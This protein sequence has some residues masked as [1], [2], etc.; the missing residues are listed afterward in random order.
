MNTIQHGNWKFDLVP[1]TNNRFTYNLLPSSNT[2]DEMHFKYDGTLYDNN[3]EL[4]CFR[5]ASIIHKLVRNHAKQLLVNGAKYIDIVES[6]ENTIALY[7]K[8]NSECKTLNIAFPIGLNVNAIAAHDSAMIDDLRILHVGDVVKCDIGIQIDGCIVDSAF[9]HIVGET[10]ES[11][12]SHELYPLIEAT[13][14]ATYTGIAMSGVDARTYEISEIIQEVIESYEVKENKINA[15]SGLGGHDIKLYKVHGSKLI[16]SVP[17][18]SQENIKME[19]GETF[20][21]ETYASTGSGK[22]IQHNLNKCSHFGTNTQKSNHSNVIA[23]WAN[24]VRYGMPFTH[25]W[26]ANIKNNDLNMIMANGLKNKSIIAYP[27]LTDSKGSY[28]A[29]TEHTIKIKKHGVEIFS[30]GSDY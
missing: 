28:T 14:D 23:D 7:A 6:I 12:L 15:V 17:H 5:K 27:P 10:N 4:S 26:C 16:L 25:R 1:N 9:T 11:I 3:Y 18:K 30:L 19:E 21:I 24:E 2:V 20:A 22:I 8:T 29:Q 13:M